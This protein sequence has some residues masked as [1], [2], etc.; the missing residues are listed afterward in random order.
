[1]TIADVREAKNVVNIVLLFV[2]ITM[3]DVVLLDAERQNQ[4]H[5]HEKEKGEKYSIIAI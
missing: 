4:I 5:V 1:M 3:K 2:A